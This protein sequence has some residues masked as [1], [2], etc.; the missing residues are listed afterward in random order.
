MNA[1]LTESA[2]SSMVAHVAEYG[3]TGVESGGFLLAPAGATVEV[4]ALAGSAQAGIVRRPEQLIISGAA[5]EVLCE[6]ADDAG[7]RIVA[8]F[9]S[10]RRGTSLSPIDKVGG[11]R[12]QEFVSIVIPRFANPET[13]ASS[14]GWWHFDSRTWRTRA[15]FDVVTG[16]TRT[17]VFDEGG[18]HDQ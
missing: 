10:H 3:I 13:D 17:I 1:E 11:M 4:V 2:V 7:L 9:H 15:A 8:Q 16:R 14:W 12:V 6:W 18:V 5:I